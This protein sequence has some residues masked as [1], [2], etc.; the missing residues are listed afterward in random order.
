MINLQTNITQN[1][2]MVTTDAVILFRT[3]CAQRKATHC[4]STL[5][6]LGFLYW[7]ISL[8]LVHKPVHCT[9]YCS[10]PVGQSTVKPEIQDGF[11]GVIKKKRIEC[12]IICD[13]ALRHLLSLATLV[14]SSDIL[15]RWKP[16]YARAT[17]QRCPFTVLS[18]FY[19]LSLST[20]WYPNSYNEAKFW[21]IKMSLSM[22]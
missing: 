1:T 11:Q 6:A 2:L 22:K 15:H 8:Q 9:S 18:L 19:N 17:T 5:L 21:W 12:G 16:S 14:T 4:E 3:S 13:T 7:V 10:S 20:K